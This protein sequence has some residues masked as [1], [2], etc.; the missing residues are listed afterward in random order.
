MNKGT[1]IR[2][3]G[4]EQ[5]VTVRATGEHVK[6][7]AWSSIAAAYRAR[8]GKRGVFFAHDDE[9]D[10]IIVHPD[11]DR[12]RHWPR[13]AASGCGAPLTPELTVC[14]TCQAPTCT[15]G[16]CRCSGRAGTASGKKRTPKKA[17]AKE[18]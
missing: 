10:E 14:P 5:W 3:F 18:K 1:V 15:C 4:P 7:E 13:C 12:G 6:I 2:R 9:L 11:D 17:V 8:S 16:R